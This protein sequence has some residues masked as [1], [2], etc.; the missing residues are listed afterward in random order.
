MLGNPGSICPEQPHFLTHGIF[1]VPQY[2]LDSIHAADFM[3]SFSGEICHSNH[4]SLGSLAGCGFVFNKKHLFTRTLGA[5]VVNLEGEVVWHFATLEPW[6]CAVKDELWIV[7]SMM[8]R[9]SKNISF[10]TRCVALAQTRQR[11]KDVTVLPLNTAYLDLW[12]EI[13]QLT[14]RGRSCRLN[15]FSINELEFANKKTFSGLWK[16]AKDEATQVAKTAMPVSPAV[17]KS[18]MQHTAVQQ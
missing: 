13:F 1:E 14:G 15:M 4:V 11:L 17:V 18:W 7:S 12:S 8:R 16:M 5:A 9:F 3:P 10:F 6:S 2:K